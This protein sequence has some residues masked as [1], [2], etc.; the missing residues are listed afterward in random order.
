MEQTLQRW[1]K[2]DMLRELETAERERRAANLTNKLLPEFSF[3]GRKI[4]AGLN[5]TGSTIQGAV[6][7]EN[8]QIQGDIIL[9]KA[10]LYRTLYITNCQVK[11]N[12]IARRANIREVVNM[13]S[14]LFKKDIDM[15]NIA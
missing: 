14:T 4:T 13:M 1:S 10:L 2:R 9:E 8:C 12:L 15:Q 11:G 7:L 3:T 5:F 6:Y